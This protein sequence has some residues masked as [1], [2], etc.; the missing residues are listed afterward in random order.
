MRLT[1]IRPRAYKTFLMLN[2]AKHDISIAHKFSVTTEPVIIE[3]AH[4]WSQI[5]LKIAGSDPFLVKPKKLML[6]H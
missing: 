2:S 6:V 4:A 3:V 1:G 5:L